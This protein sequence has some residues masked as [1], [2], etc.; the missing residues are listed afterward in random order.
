MAE[1]LFLTRKAAHWSA[2]V[3][4]AICGPALKVKKKQAFPDG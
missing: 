1:N 4:R 3:G 2:A